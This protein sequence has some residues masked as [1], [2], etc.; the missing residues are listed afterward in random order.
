MP[1][2][3]ISNNC[4]GGLIHSHFKEVYYNPFIYSLILD[5]IQFIDLCSNFDDIIKCDHIISSP[6][7]NLKWYKDTNKKSYN[8]WNYYTTDISGIEIHWIHHDKS[9]ENLLDKFNRRRLRL[10]DNYNS[11]SI[12][13]LFNFFTLFQDHT[14]DEFYAL[15]SKFLKNNHRSISLLPDDLSNNIYNLF[16]N[17]KHICVKMNNMQFKEL[18][19]NPWNYGNRDTEDKRLTF[20][21]YINK[22]K[23]VTQ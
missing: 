11:T 7:Y 16:D 12:I 15:L 6:N 1:Y 2:T 8:D 22:I 13:F 17:D 18:C 19:R 14:I 5:D 10:I 3:Y 9:T 23:G 20:I 4:M 21:E